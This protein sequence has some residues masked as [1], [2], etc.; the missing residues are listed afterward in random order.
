MGAQAAVKYAYTA[1]AF[2]DGGKKDA[3]AAGYLKLRYT[4]LAGGT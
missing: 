3:G 4:H 2:G 1:F